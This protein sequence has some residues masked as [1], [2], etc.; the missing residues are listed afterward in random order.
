MSSTW[1][2]TP[3]F[4]AH[5][6]AS[7]ARRSASGPPASFQCPTFAV[8]DGHQ[9]HMMP[10]PRPFHR[11]A[12]RFVLRIIGMR[13]EHDDA[14]LAVVLVFGVKG[15]CGETGDECEDESDHG[16]GVRVQARTLFTL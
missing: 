16:A 15:E 13:A 14:Q 9:L 7:A 1:E 12:G 11:S 8:R 6:A 5:A 4:L 2:V 10:Q 3:S